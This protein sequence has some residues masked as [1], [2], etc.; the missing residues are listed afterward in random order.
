MTDNRIGSSL[1]DIQMS[2][3]AGAA[4]GIPKGARRGDPRSGARSGPG[5]VATAKQRRFSASEK[6]Q[7]LAEAGACKKP[8]EVGALLCRKRIYASMLSTWRRQRDE[9]GEKALAPLGRGRKADPA[10]N[11]RVNFPTSGK[12]KF[13]TR[14]PYATITKYPPCSGL[15]RRTRRARSDRGIR[16][17]ALGSGRHRGVPGPGRAAGNGLPGSASAQGHHLAR[18][19]DSSAAREDLRSFASLSIQ[20]N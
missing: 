5:V 3:A 20:S 6:R 7:I 18:A 11:G 9:A 12:V 10:V 15:R 19:A 8:G 4:P 14:S 17:P 16:H 13:P 1:I 2:S